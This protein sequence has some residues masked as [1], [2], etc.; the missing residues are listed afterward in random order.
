MTSSR[1]PSF[2]RFARE[3]GFTGIF[4]STLIPWIGRTSSLQ[5]SVVTFMMIIVALGHVTA[6]IAM[7]CFTRADTTLTPNWLI[8][9][10]SGTPSKEAQNCGRMTVI[11]EDEPL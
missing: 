8:L 10:S 2:A 6:M 4:S 1:A 5:S 7:S 9:F 3:E 11:L